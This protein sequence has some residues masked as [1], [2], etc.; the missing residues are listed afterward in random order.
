VGN[1]AVFDAGGAVGAML[2]AWYNASLVMSNITVKNGNAVVGSDM[3]ST[4]KGN[5]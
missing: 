4:Y 5:M 3:I 1:G 2:C